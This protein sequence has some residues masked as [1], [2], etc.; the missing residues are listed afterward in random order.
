MQ[1]F[2]YR[3]IH[4]PIWLTALTVFSPYSSQSTSQN[5]CN[6]DT[7]EV[8]ENERHEQYE[9]RQ[10]R[11]QLPTKRTKIIPKCSPPTSSASSQWLASPS[12]PP[13][14]QL[15]SLAQPTP[16]AATKSA[17]THSTA[18]LNA[19]Y[20]MKTVLIRQTA[21]HVSPTRSHP[22]FIS[23]LF[24]HVHLSKYPFCVK[25]SGSSTDCSSIIAASAATKSDLK[26]TCAYGEKSEASCC[27][28]P[29]AAGVEVMCQAL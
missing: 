21:L 12:Q 29:S 28:V 24:P 8:H 13:P 22:I 3:D 16:R 5:L 4:P 27:S 2:V 15:S 18:R 7:Q 19:A 1:R 20:P 26:A 9:T 14:Q 23:F 10:H 6:P 11:K 17:P 25:K